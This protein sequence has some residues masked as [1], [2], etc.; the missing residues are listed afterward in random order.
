MPRNLENFTI[1][2][3]LVAD[4]SNVPLNPMKNSNGETYYVVTFD[5][6]MNFGLTELQG[7]LRWLERVSDPLMT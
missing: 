1:L 6:V 2:C 3:R 5:V 7:Q 4:L